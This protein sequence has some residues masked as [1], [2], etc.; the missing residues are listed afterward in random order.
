M[1]NAGAIDLTAPLIKGQ[2]GVDYESA[3]EL[4]KDGWNA[5]TLHLYSH[6][7]THMDSQKHFGAGPET[8]DTLPLDRCMGP[9]HVVNLQDRVSESSLIEIEDLGGVLNIFKAGES[10]LLHT[11]WSR[12]SGNDDIFR[13]KLPRISESLATWCV[14]HQ[15][16]VLGVEPPSV[17]DVT[18]L[19]EVTR[20]HK[21]L[22]E[23]EITIV[24]GLCNLAQLPPY[25]Q[26]MALPLKIHEGDGA[27][28]RAIAWPIL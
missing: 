9:A 2:R 17:A 21:I 10:L 23:G 4:E 18:N 22:L 5:R 11:G 7:G 1:T 16:K 27:P 3:R 13:K 6:A 20:I 12:F 28:A 15:V 24:E 19:E 25:V 26:F 14:E 8:I